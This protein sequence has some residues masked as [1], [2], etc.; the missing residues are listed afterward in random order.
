MAV[1]VGFDDSLP[2]GKGESGSHTA[3]PIWID[4]MKQAHRDL[5]VT[6]FARP[7]DI[8]VAEVDPRTGLL[9][10]PGQ[11]DAVRE[12]FLAG[13]VPTEVATEPGTEGDEEEGDE[14]EGAGDESDDEGG[15]TRGARD[16]PTDDQPTHDEPTEDEPR[17]TDDSGEV[18]APRNERREPQADDPEVNRLP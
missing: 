6:D 14:E 5:P 7:N 13:S 12:E 8:V 9:P 3:L 2:L 10:Y 16:E 1:W 15:D 18:A 11:T 4:F 17:A